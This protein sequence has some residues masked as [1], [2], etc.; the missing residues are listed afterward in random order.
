VNSSLRMDAPIR[1]CRLLATS[2]YVRAPD[3]MS[4]RNCVATNSTFVCSGISESG[5]TGGRKIGYLVSLR[6]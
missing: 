2:N 1:K 4:T 6:G 3:A 5:R